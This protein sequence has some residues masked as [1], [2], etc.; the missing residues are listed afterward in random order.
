MLHEG[1]DLVDFSPWK[2]AWHTV[3]AQKYSFSEYW[4]NTCDAGPR[5]KMRAVL[6]LN[7]LI[8][9]GKMEKEKRK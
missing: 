4:L 3:D 8:F 2:C 5:K 9:G 1:E 6:W 7:L